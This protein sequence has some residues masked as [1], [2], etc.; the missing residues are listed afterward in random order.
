[1]WYFNHTYHR[2]RLFPTH[3]GKLFCLSH[4][5]STNQN[6]VI[7]HMLQGRALHINKKKLH[8][9]FNIILL[10]CVWCDLPY[11]ILPNMTHI[12][13]LKSVWCMFRSIGFE[14]EGFISLLY[15]NW[16]YVLD[17][18]VKLIIVGF[19]MVQKMIF[20]KQCVRLVLP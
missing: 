19:C 6:F 12:I 15:I 16:Q 9:L 7:I 5:F 3:C 13:E 11:S 20:I 1:M 2:R 4:K 17:V 8:K 10:M 14:I 18:N